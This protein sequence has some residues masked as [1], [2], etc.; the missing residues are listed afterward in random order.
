MAFFSIGEFEQ[1]APRTVKSARLL[2]NGVEMHV[3]VFNPAGSGKHVCTVAVC[4]PTNTSAEP[5]YAKIG[6][7]ATLGAAVD[8][9]N[10]IAAD[11]AGEEPRAIFGPF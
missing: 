10:A 6:S 5:Q 2:P 8:A 7:F 3:T 1:S 9:A 11:V 4:L